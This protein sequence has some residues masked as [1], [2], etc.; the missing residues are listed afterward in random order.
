[1]IIHVNI[2]HGCFCTIR[3]ELN[4]CDRVYI[5]HKAKIFIIWSFTENVCRPLTLHQL[6]CITIAR[7]LVRDAHAWREEMYQDLAEDEWLGKG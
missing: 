1:M 5:V 7:F 2:L 4:S 6:L 3:A